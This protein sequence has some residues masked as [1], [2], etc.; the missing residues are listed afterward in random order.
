MDS[1]F[2]LLDRWRAGDAKAGEEL[3]TRHFDSLCG[4][5]ATKCFGDAD[6]LV[7][8]TLLATVR[9][10]DQFRKQSS[11]RT[12]LFTL[13]R[14][15]LYHYLQELRRDGVLDF[16]ITSIR[17]IITTPASRLARDAERRRVIEVLRTLP[18]E[19]Q[20][21]LEL[22]Y[23]EE[24]DSDALAEVF[25][26]TPGAIRVRLTRARKLLRDALLPG[27]EEDALDAVVRRGKRS[28]SDG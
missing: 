3:F 28:S 22:H 23:W 21:L 8:R 25:D 4:F 12:Y 27:G 24:L 2:D 14:N 16:S 18:V 1:D 11:F 6:D 7:Q 26:T 13:A 10:K 19:Q 9:G 17:D 15:E 20:T 5:F